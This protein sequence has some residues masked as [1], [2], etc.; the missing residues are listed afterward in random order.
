M[1]KRQALEKAKVFSELVI[2][3]YHPKKIILFG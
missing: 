3:K 1:D 2:K